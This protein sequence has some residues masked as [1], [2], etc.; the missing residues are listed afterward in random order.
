M[1]KMNKMSIKNCFVFSVMIVLMISYVIAYNVDVTLSIKG[2]GTAGESWEKSFSGDTSAKLYAPFEN[3]VGPEG[4]VHIEFNEDVTLGEIN[5]IEWMQYVT[6]GYPAHVDIFLDVN[7]NGDT[8]DDDQLVVEFAYNPMDPHNAR[9]PPYTV[10]GDY[11]NWFST[12]KDEIVIDSDTNM[13]LNSGSAGP[14][15]WVNGTLKNWKDGIP[16]SAIDASTKVLALEIEV[17]GWI[18]ESQAYIDNIKLNGE[19][20]ENFEDNQQVTGDLEDYYWSIEVT[21]A[22]LNFGSIK[23]GTDIIDND[24]GPVTLNADSSSTADGKVY[25]YTDVTGAD[26]GFYKNLLEFNISFSWENVLS[27]G[28]I[29]PEETSESYETQLHGDTTIYLS[30]AKSATIVYTAYGASL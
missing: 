10:A 4:R 6:M 27:A 15:T 29:I 13:W 14:P 2:D 20:I 5:S 25:V 1:R 16:L 28:F 17:D 18:A 26:S 22:T 23:R 9:G 12:F 30:G 21:P 19:M 11:D 3:S 7:N 24:A 8:S